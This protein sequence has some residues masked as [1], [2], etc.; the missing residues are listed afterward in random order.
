[1]LPFRDTFTRFLTTHPSYLL[2]HL[3]ASAR[4]FCSARSKW[5]SI[6]HCKTRMLAIKKAV[7]G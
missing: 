3:D 6:L 1:M 5:Y 7:L 4:R 2:L